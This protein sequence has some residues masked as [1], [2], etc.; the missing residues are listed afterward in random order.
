MREVVP[1]A[2][3]E[4]PGPGEALRI[5]AA[6]M[7]LRAIALPSGDREWEAWLSVSDL[8]GTT[9]LALLEAVGP[10]ARTGAGSLV[11]KVHAVAGSVARSGVRR[12]WKDRTR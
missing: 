11:A 10:P 6:G 1:H 9:T 3:T 12:P 4:A 5:V 7:G 8:S 2:G